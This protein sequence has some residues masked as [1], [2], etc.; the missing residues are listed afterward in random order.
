MFTSS[1]WGS[2]QRQMTTTLSAAL[3]SSDVSGPVTSQAGAGYSNFKQTAPTTP[4]NSSSGPAA[5]QNATVDLY[6]II[7]VRGCLAP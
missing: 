5:W 6:M 4:T 3:L 7:Y 1:I 2:D